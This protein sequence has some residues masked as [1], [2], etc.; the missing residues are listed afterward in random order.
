MSSAARPFRH[1]C[2]EADARDAMTD[3]EFW[4]HVFSSYCGVDMAPEP[5]DFPTPPV[6][7]DLPH[8]GGA[9][10]RMGV[11]VISDHVSPC[12]VCHEWGACGY[13]IEGRPMI[14]ALY[15]DGDE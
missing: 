4:D 15:D 5:D 2:P 12:P 8:M 6:R 11:V 7:G 3:A 1:L 14:H 9:G 13:D 10:A